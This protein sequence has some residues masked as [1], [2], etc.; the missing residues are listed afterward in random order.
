[1]PYVVNVKRSAEKELSRL[2]AR[3]HDRIVGHLLS[4][5]ENPRPR[6][7]KRLRGRDEYRL[8]VGDYRILYIIDESA[9]EIEIVAVGHRRDV[10]R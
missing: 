9:K 8:R 4:L 5:G 2:P 1:M 10:Y 3:I 7:A 6:M